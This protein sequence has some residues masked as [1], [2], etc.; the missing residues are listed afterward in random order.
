MCS[1]SN[2]NTKG[3][4]PEA[5][6]TFKF[7]ETCS[8][9]NT[10]SGLLKGYHLFKCCK[11]SRRDRCA[12]RS[13]YPAPPMKQH[14]LH[15]NEA[16]HF[17]YVKVILRALP[18]VGLW[19]VQCTNREQTHKNATEFVRWHAAIFLRQQLQQ[20][21]TQTVFPACVRVSC[22]YNVGF[23]SLEAKGSPGTNFQITKC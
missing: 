11:D 15:K 6:N 14:T 13:L 19:Y 21:V 23:I 10:S 9:K 2:I 4:L 20:A 12:E 8:Q 3:L 16:R 7:N 18:Q 22:Y 17:K 5:E 1:F